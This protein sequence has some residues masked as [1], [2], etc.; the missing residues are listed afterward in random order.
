M[1]SF[2]LSFVPFL[3]PSCHAVSKAVQPLERSGGETQV[4]RNRSPLPK[5]IPVSALG[6]LSL[7]QNP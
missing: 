1:N 4:E 6:P 3:E 2:F 5:K 7:I